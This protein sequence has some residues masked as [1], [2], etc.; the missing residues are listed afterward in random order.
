METAILEEFIAFTSWCSMEWGS[1]FSPYV[2]WNDSAPP[3]YL[4][5]Q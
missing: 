1:D 3:L 5:H 2:I 4:K